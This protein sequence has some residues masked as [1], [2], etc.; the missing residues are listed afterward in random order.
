M[1]ESF[2]KFEIA[3]RTQNLEIKERTQK[4]YRF[5]D[6][7]SFKIALKKWRP[8]NC[9]CRIPKVYIANICFV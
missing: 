4:V 6:Q 9:P 2:E 5:Q 7:N 3:K 8:V 1:N